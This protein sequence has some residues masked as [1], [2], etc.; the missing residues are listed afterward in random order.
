MSHTI[1][2]QEITSWLD[3]PQLHPQRLTGFDEVSSHM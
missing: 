3:Q 2:C 1:L